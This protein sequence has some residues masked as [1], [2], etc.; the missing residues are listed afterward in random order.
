MRRFEHVEARG[1]VGKGLSMREP[2]ERLLGGETRRHDGTSGVARLHEMLGE[3]CADL[4][5]TGSVG[6]L[7]PYPDSPVRLRALSGRESPVEHLSVQVVREPVP[8]CERPVRPP[9]LAGRLDEPP[10]AREG[11]AAR[12]DLG[13]G[14]RGCGRGGSGR[15]LLP[16]CARGG[17][18]LTVER[19]ELL[20]RLLDQLADRVRYVARKTGEVGLAF[21]QQALLEP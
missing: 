16:D 4:L 15:E 7:E 20:E 13:L 6:G 8:G 12:V 21:V 14:E 5:R 18:K 17:E 11:V 3:F 10:C 2:L 9:L 1:Q 19:V